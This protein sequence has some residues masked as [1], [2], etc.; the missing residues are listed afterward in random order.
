MLP[1]AWC[2]RIDEIDVG[3]MVASDVAVAIIMADSGLTPKPC[4]KK[5]ST[6]TI[7]IP[8]PTPK[9]PAKI[10]AKIPVAIKATIIGHWFIISVMCVPTTLMKQLHGHQSEDP[11]Q[12]QGL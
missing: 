7:T 6:G 12:L 4:S 2:E 10:P 3:T 11:L 1:F 8:P 9:S 5:Y